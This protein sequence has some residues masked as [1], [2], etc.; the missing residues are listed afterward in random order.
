MRLR[1]FVLTTHRWMG[2]CVSLILAIAG[3]TGVFLI[4]PG[5][6]LLRKVAGKL[7]ENLALGYNGRMIVLAASA[8]GV[9]LEF[10]GLYLWWNRKTLRIRLRSGWQRA[11]FDL[12]HAAGAICL[13]IMLVLAV[14]AVTMGYTSSSETRRTANRLHTARSFSL[15]VQIV[16]AL[17]TIGFA[18]Q[19]TTGV[20]MYLRK[21]GISRRA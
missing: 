7:H 19:G 9:L 14:T 17:G 12:H 18:V 4:W 10:G 15:P 20:L 11:V 1:Q 21:L 8:V 16:Y 2:L 5:D 6:Y 13:V 3:G